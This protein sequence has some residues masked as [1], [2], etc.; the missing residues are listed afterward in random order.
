MP[1]HADATITACS[2]MRAR[3]A[4]ERGRRGAI[5]DPVRQAMPT[6]E[7]LRGLLHAM[8]DSPYD[9]RRAEPARPLLLPQRPGR[10]GVQRPGLPRPLRIDGADAAR[11]Q[12][13]PARRSSR[14]DCGARVL[15]LLYCQTC[16]ELFLGG[17]RSAG[18][19]RRPG[20]WYLVAD[21]PE[22]ERLPDRATSRSDCE[23]LRAVLAAPRRRASGQD[24]GRAAR[25]PSSS[26]FRACELRPAHRTARQRCPRRDGLALRRSRHR[27]ERDLP[28]TAD[29]L[30]ALR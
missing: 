24:A 4:T 25:R 16:G 18:P 1:S 5:A 22:L 11:R 15:E 20:A 14:C 21:L 27:P 9:A 8:D 29:A 2:A 3:A 28:G 7:A 6:P 17:W 12:A 10:L 23:Q 19:R 26:A 13:L 30:P